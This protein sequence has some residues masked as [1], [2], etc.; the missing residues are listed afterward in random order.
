MKAEGVFS[1]ESGGQEEIMAVLL[2]FTHEI[3]DTGHY[4]TLY[5]G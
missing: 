1:Y 5:T 3:K 2:N 4:K